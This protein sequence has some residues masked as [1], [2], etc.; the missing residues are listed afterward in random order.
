MD[1]HRVEVIFDRI[2]QTDT[3]NR[4]MQ[5]QAEQ[6][7]QL[8]I[9]MISRYTEEDRRREEREYYDRVE[10]EQQAS[11]AA[12][13]AEEERLAE[14][15]RLRYEQ[16][17]KEAETAHLR[18]LAAEKLKEM[19]KQDAEKA[20]AK[21]RRE[22][23]REEREK[24]EA[25]AIVGM[26]E[27]QETQRRKRQEELERQRQQ[28]EEEEELAAK[29]A[30]AAARKE[31][32]EAE[33]AKEEARRRQQRKAEKQR[34]DEEEEHDEP[35]R[36]RPAAGKGTH[37]SATQVEITV[38]RKGKGGT[39]KK[40]HKSTGGGKDG[41][42]HT[43]S[44][45]AF[46]GEKFARDMERKMEREFEGFEAEFFDSSSDDDEYWSDDA[47][48][49]RHAKAKKSVKASARAG[50]PHSFVN[51]DALRAGIQ[52]MAMA[53]VHSYSRPHSPYY[54][55]HHPSSPYM[56]PPP[57]GPYPYEYVTSSNHANA[58]SISV[59]NVSNSAISFGDTPAVVRN[60]GNVRIV[61]ISNVG[62]RY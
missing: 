10:H 20:N 30:A 50:R 1:N 25:I 41:G 55:P 29:K 14:E 9:T 13:R 34:R 11:V 7:E 58:T 47:P 36:R 61:N 19:D 17:R 21:K 37:I 56:M 12:L 43:Y 48:R 35:S 6:M 2:H 59:S 24:R 45:V 54:P 15:G 16:E 22:Q 46:D 3:L 4:L 62:N 57:P 32:R 39:T 42:A 51:V 5:Q 28:E 18:E 23:A 38:T 52:D 44:N 27:R 31:A 49:K 40:V 60:S 8:R 53:G 33:E 26:Q